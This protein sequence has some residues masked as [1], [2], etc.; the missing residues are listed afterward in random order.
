MKQYPSIPN[1]KTMKFGE[2]S[3]IFYKYDGSNLR[4]EWSKKKSFYKAGTRNRLFDE[5]DEI[6]GEAISLFENKYAEQLE[7]TLVNNYKN[8]ERAMFFTEFFGNNSFAGTHKKSDVKELKLFDV[9]IYKKG[10]IDPF[11]FVNNFGHLDFSAEV[12][13]KG[14]FTKPMI[15]E[16][17]DSQTLNEGV[18]VKGGKGH[19]IWMAKIKTLIY[20]ERLQNF[21]NNPEKYWE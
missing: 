16:I 20:W 12:L 4:W 18:I 11:E 21:T 5:T 6:F 14:K 7:R 13:F 1:S 10:L 9:N 17:R 2:E 19:K 8:V 3:I 15:Q